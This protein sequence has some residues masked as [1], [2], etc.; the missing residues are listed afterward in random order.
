MGSP[1]LRAASSTTHTA[2][3]P[4]APARAVQL[5]A[6]RPG[7]SPRQERARPQLGTLACGCSAIRGIVPPRTER[8]CTKQRGRD[9]VYL[10]FSINGET[11]CDG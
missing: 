11:Y 9:L 5:D 10:S 4:W 1:R 2:R 7:S 6:R 8:S 3:V